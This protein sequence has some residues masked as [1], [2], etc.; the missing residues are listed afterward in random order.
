[1]HDEEHSGR[2]YIIMDGLV[3][4]VLEHIMENRSFTVTKLSSHFPQISR[5]SLHKIVTEHL[6]FR[7]LHARWVPKQLTPEYKAKRMESVAVP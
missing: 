7:K 1:M 4:L 6:L 3:Q 2:P 5:S